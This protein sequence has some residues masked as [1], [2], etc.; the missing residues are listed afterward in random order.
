MELTPEK[1]IWSVHA[2]FELLNGAWTL[3]KAILR[4]PNASHWAVAEALPPISPRCRVRR[5]RAVDLASAPLQRCH[6]E[7]EK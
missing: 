6:H 2:P 3:R 5:D 1:R 7:P 4:R